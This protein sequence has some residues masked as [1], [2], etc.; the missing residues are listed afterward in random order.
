MLNLMNKFIKEWQP[1]D[2]IA[3]VV[4]VACFVLIGLG[5]NHIVSGVVIMVCTYYFRK[6]VEEVQIKQKNESSQS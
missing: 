1:K 5:I 2:V 4:L 6:R 3:L